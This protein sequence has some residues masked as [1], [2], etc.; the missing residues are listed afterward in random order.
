MELVALREREIE[1]KAHDRV[2]D[3]QEVLSGWEKVYK[4]TNGASS[5]MTFD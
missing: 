5:C 2:Q 3:M 4:S 1:H